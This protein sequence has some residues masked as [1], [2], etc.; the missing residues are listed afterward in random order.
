MY[1]LIVNISHAYATQTL[2]FE[3]DFNEMSKILVTLIILFIF[4]EHVFIFISQFLF[5]VKTIKVIPGRKVRSTHPVY[6]APCRGRKRSLSDNFKCRTHALAPYV[7]RFYDQVGL[8][9]RF[10]RGEREKRGRGSILAATSW[11]T[12]REKSYRISMPRYLPTSAPEWI[13]RVVAKV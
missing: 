12:S 8:S 1:I 4:V 7:P 5:V 11:A 9:R 13:P 10:E 3:H 6:I 2:I